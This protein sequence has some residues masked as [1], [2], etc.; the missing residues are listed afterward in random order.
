MGHLDLSM[1][2]DVEREVQE[3]NRLETY[4]ELPEVKQLA[5]NQ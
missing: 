4:T 5:E 2:L 1:S 3:A